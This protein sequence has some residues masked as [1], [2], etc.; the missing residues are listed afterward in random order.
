VDTWRSRWSG[1]EI[2]LRGDRSLYLPEAGQVLA[3]DC[4]LGK[5]EVF[6][7]RGLPVPI[8]DDRDSLGRLRRAIA[9]TGARGLTLCGDLL[10]DPRAL[11]IER[12]DALLSEVAGL[13]PRAVTLV[14]GNHDRLSDAVLL[15]AGIQ[16]IAE[17]SLLGIRLLHEP[18]MGMQEDQS[19]WI[20]GH[21]HPM[22]RFRGSGEQVR[23]PGF[24]IDDRSIILPAFGPF[25]GGPTWRRRPGQQLIGAW[26]GQLLGVQRDK[27][28]EKP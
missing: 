6:Q 23:C 21:L 13:C 5:A 1:T 10:H 22:L 27:Q 26:Y 15:A 8:G 16:P 24:V 11:S 14:K 12:R 9:D 4:H 2:R 19:P 18:P 3:S 17:A 7:Q 20:A 28:R 25:T